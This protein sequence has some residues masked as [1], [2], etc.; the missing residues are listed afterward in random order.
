MAA[1][2]NN[3]GLDLPGEGK[4]ALKRVEIRSEKRKVMVRGSNGPGL[5]VKG[6]GAI[7]ESE[8][9]KETCV[10]IFTAVNTAVKNIFMQIAVWSGALVLESNGLGLSHNPHR[11]AA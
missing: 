10:Q 3:K 11:Q 1:V 7:G 2:L 4:E 8:W 9:S 5:N 6:F